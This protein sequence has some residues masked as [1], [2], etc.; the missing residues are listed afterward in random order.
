MKQTTED[1]IE[2]MMDDNIMTITLFYGEDIKQED[3]TALQE[4][5][6]AKYPECEVT[7]AAGGQPVYYY[8]ISLE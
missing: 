1:L 4:K 2:K 3:A 8:L 5:L 7:V 6:A